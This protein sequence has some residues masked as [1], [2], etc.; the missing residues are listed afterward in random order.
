MYDEPGGR[1]RVQNLTGK[2]IPNGAPAYLGGHVGFV[3]K[4]TQLDRWVKPGS[5]EAT[6][7]MDKEWCVMFVIDKHE[8]ALAGL[9]ATA[10]VGDKLFFDGDSQEVVLA[11]GAGA[12]AANEKQSVKIEATG[13]TS[14]WTVPVFEDPAEQTGKIKWD[15]TAKEVQEALDALPGLNP[16][17]VVV[18]GG[19]GDATGTTPYIL[20]FGGRLADTD[21]AATTV[22]TTE[23]TGEKKATITTSTAGAG[24][25]DTVMP[26]GVVD[27]IDT[28]RS[29]SVALV[30]CSDLKPFLT[31]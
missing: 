3:G 23:L 29:P 21:V 15:A 16:G 17:D 14:K 1:V 10:S 7:V 18:T 22:D 6:H 20:T 12:S 11:A 9:L 19:P 13:G 31:S 30:N 8:L 27:V 26:L 4:N 5:E 28:S 24:S 25:A 2:A